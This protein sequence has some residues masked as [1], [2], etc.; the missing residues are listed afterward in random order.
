[1]PL[2]YDNF[3]ILD[4]P[5]NVYDKIYILITCKQNNIIIHNSLKRYTK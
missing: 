1:M 4:L 2:Q 3:V 5:A